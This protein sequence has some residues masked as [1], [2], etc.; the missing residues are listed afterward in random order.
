NA[1]SA[2]SPSAC[3]VM[4]SPRT[5]PRVSTP[6]MLFALAVFSPWRSR[7]WERNWAA[8]CTRS[9]AGRACRPTWFVIITLVSTTGTIVVL[10]L[11]TAIMTF[12]QGVRAGSCLRYFLQAV[13]DR[14]LNSRNHCTLDQGSGTD[15]D[16]MALI[17]HEGLYRHL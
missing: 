10:S 15:D 5:T 6:S 12:W 2:S 14:S 13:A 7:I 16:I 9:R 8:V 4:V 3:N 11:S 1:S 17:L